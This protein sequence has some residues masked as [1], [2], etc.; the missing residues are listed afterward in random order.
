MLTQ[1]QKGHVAMTA[2]CKLVC[3]MQGGGKKF[4]CILNTS[5]LHHGQTKTDDKC[6]H[7]YEIL[8]NNSKMPKRPWLFPSPP[9]IKWAYILTGILT[10]KCHTEVPLEQ[11]EWCWKTAEQLP[12]PTLV[13]LWRYSY[14]LKK[15]MASVKLEYS[16][17]WPSVWTC[18][19]SFMAA[20]GTGS[21]SVWG[22]AESQKSQWVILLCPI[23][24]GGEHYSQYSW[25]W[26]SLTRPPDFFQQ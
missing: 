6:Q 20:I 12:S 17:L 19:S 1:S 11:R 14:I 15:F 7:S 3:Y 9:Q 8:S 2:R 23:T 18:H 24:S 5:T 10:G 21:Q 22:E 16:S 25:Q 4:A 26:A 13:K